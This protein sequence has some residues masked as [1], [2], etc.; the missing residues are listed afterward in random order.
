MLYNFSMG[1]SVRTFPKT[2]FQWVLVAHTCNLALEW[3]QENQLLIE[4]ETRLKYLRLVPK[5]K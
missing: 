4:F 2:N 5:T 3:R 1:Y